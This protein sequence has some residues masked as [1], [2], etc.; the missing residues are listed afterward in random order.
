MER[1]PDNHAFT[2]G[3]GRSATP[4]RSIETPTI[5]LPKGGG[6]LRGIDEKFTVNA[7]NGTAAFSLG[8][9]FSHSRSAFGPAL[10]LGYNS[11]GGNSP[12]GLGW[13][14]EPGAIQ[15]RTDKK[16]PTYDNAHG[17][18]VFQLAGVEDLV[19]VLEQVGSTWVP[20]VS[21]DGLV[22]QYRPRI[23]G[24]FARIEQVRRVGTAIFYWKV[25]SADNHTT[26]YGR[27]ADSRIADPTDPTRIYRWLP[28][29]SH[30]DQGNCFEYS[31]KT[32]D[33]SQVPPLLSEKNRQN[34][35]QPTANRYLNRIRHGNHTP[36]YPDPARPYTPETPAT[37]YFFDAV[38]DYGEYDPDAPAPAI[39][40]TTWACR[41]DPFSDNH[42]GFELRTCRLCRRVLFFHSFA[43][44]STPGPV[45][46]YLVRSIDFTYRHFRFDN[47]PHTPQEADFITVIQ[48]H[49]YERLTN[50]TYVRSA[51]P[52]VEFSYN[53]LR[54]NTAV[55]VVRR[56]DAPNLP[57]GLANGYQWT[58]FYGEGIAGVISEQAGG[59]YYSANRGG[60]RFESA[61]LVAPRPSFSGLGTGGLRLQDLEANG[62]KYLVSLSGEMTG[63][64]EQTDAGGWLPFRTFERFPTVNPNDPSA[65]WIDLDG[66][67]M[68]ELVV[69]EEQ[70]FVWYESQ[71]R[72]GYNAPRHTP[73]PLDEERGPAI[74][75][76]D[77]L[78]R[79][80]TA[81]MSGDGLSDIVRVRN[82]EVCYWPNQGYGRFG[83]KV[84]M[85]N[86]PVFDAPD[87]FN[88]AY[89]HLT[90]ISGTGATDLLY[91]GKN[92]IMA[93]INLTGNAWTEGQ[94][95][96]PFPSLELPNQLTVCDF[97]GNGTGSLV[98]SSPSPANA[99]SPL[100]YI[101]LMGGRK[102]YVLTEY[103]NN[104]GKTVSYT[105]RSST[106]FYLDDKA[107]GTPWQTKL[108]FPVQCVSRVEQHDAVTNMR[109]V[110]LYGYHHGYYDR[111]EREFRGFGRVEQRATETFENWT[112]QDASNIVEQPFHES[113]ML[114]K[115]WYHTG[116]FLDRERV[117]TR[118]ETEYWYHAARLLDP[119]LI[120]A[121]PQLPDARLPAGL[122]EI[123]QREAH[124]V[125]GLNCI[126]WRRKSLSRELM[127]SQKAGPRYGR[128]R[129]FS[130]GASHP[131]SWSAGGEGRCT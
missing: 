9:P 62:K 83:A 2:L 13:A 36:Y 43:E 47:T 67:G 55:T 94:P 129:E 90:E 103:R 58:D 68:P 7:A 57:T 22:R 42:A 82:E 91:T 59:W 123:E 122:T 40:P 118:F 109:F 71:G 88:P 79:I 108:P 30:D 19:P 73:K 54:W 107:A 23:E 21:A 53:E 69:A 39:T 3:S 60:G 6:A 80:Y 50:G 115:T 131:S 20:V 45:T 101:D 126:F 119:A 100:R 77:E 105:Y 29:L 93:Y 112:R 27:S 125:R 10:T 92:R 97:T 110:S 114:T 98:W 46:P 104:L 65:K 24:A 16:L 111:A 8:L 81:D 12:F 5:S 130:S 61:A 78:Q 17:E 38:F 25:T 87:G 85:D 1:S 102:P 106:E 35:L 66:D 86:A 127:Q 76:T 18:D 37:A 128:P 49:G 89:L 70:V 74:V 99:E 113:V 28:V 44:L 41:W 26:F 84:T 95:I 121:E 75:F 15:R 33:R 31:Y 14:A 117:L 72:A 32:G 11:G 64:F 124:S 52:P 34:G 96:E 48:Q 63:F 4:S 56:T 116:V 120:V 51:L